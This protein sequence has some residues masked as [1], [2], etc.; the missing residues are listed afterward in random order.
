MGINRDLPHRFRW[1]TDNNAQVVITLW[2]VT[3]E[4]FEHRCGDF[5]SHLGKVSWEDF[6]LLSSRFPIPCQLLGLGDLRGSHLLG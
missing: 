4:V 6:I 5:P 2:T 1:I 3:V